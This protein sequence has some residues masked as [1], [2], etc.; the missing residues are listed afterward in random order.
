[1]TCGQVFFQVSFEFHPLKKT[2]SGNAMS[3]P[4]EPVDGAF[5]FFFSYL[6]SREI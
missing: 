5:E 4:H 2:G 1:L 6:S 3:L